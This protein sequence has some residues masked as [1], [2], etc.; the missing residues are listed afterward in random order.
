MLAAWCVLSPSAQAAV[1]KYHTLGGLNNRNSFLTVLEAESLMPVFL[2]RAHF[3][4]CSSCLLTVPSHGLPWYMH[5][6]R[7]STYSGV[8]TYMNTNS[9]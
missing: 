9:S 2:I 4:D 8:P 6:E 7:E 1:A 3:P 5:R